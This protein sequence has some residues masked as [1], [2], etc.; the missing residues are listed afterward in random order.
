[1]PS[2]FLKQV[3]PC[4]GLLVLLCACGPTTE[5]YA[6]FAQAGV[7]YSNALDELLV[8]AGTTRID[9]NSEALLS[10]KRLLTAPPTSAAL[11]A[12]GNAIPPVEKSVSGIPPSQSQTPTG[13]LIVSNPIAP[14][15][16]E[17]FCRNLQP[18]ASGELGVMTASR[19]DTKQ[20]L[21]ESYENYTRCDKER[22][23]VLGMLR[24]QADLLGQYFL[25]LNELATSDSPEQ[26]AIA[27][28][29][30]GDGIKKI[31]DNLG[32]SGIKANLISNG[33]LSGVLSGLGKLIIRSEIKGALGRELNQRKDTIEKALA[34]QTLLLDALGSQVQNDIILTQQE[35]ETRQIINPYIDSSQGSMGQEWVDN[36]RAILTMNTTANELTKANNASKGMQT[37]FGELVS[38]K[39][40]L[41]RANTVLADINLFVDTVTKLKK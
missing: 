27:A 18:V 11:S 19:S 16:L 8:V 2:I 35:R 29:N 40:T 41:A 4:A 36:R 34:L 6:K 20:T 32:P 21:L 5:E 10:N 13:L 15:K 30:I 12:D 14:Q 28:G 25:K 7:A 22:L 24:E 3:V 23:V 38:G 31:S 37:A 39:L 26:V 17:E 1:M 33:S 9:A